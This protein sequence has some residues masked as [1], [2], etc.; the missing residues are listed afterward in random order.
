MELGLSVGVRRVLV[1]FALSQ[2]GAASTQRFDFPS[3]FRAFCSSIGLCVVGPFS[4][5]TP[6]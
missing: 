5:P 2:Q 4:G 3:K 6:L 1:G